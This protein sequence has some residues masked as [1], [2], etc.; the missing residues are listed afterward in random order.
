M[1]MK[2]FKEAQEI[3]KDIVGIENLIKKCNEPM[4][5]CGQIGFI[6][7]SVIKDITNKLKELKSEYEKE[8]EKLE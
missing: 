5:L 3:Y 6:K 4:F 7:D 2:A 1:D 8:F